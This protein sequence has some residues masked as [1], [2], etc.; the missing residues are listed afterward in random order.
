MHG[1]ITLYANGWPT[2]LFT[3]QNITK[4]LARVVYACNHVTRE[5]STSKC[6]IQVSK[7]SSAAEGL[8]RWIM[9]MEIYD[10]VAKV[11]A[12]KKAKL[13]EAQ[14]TLAETMTLLNEKRAEL[15]AVQDRLANLE[16]TFQEMVDKKKNLE[17]QVC[18]EA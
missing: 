17:F 8:T 7:A 4:I 15:K 3:S 13:K 5:N 6:L 9:A 18:T 11:V 12:P 1:I 10:R 14:A 16:K 2:V